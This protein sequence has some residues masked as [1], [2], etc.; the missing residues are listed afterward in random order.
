MLVARL[1]D[2]ALLPRC[3]PIDLLSVD[4]D[5]GR[6]PDRASARAG[7]IE[8]ERVSP[9]REWRLVEVDSTLG[10]VEAARGRIEALMQPQDTYM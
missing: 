1:A 8:L 5:G 4:F 10:E 2:A 7:V 9:R 6:S 3:C